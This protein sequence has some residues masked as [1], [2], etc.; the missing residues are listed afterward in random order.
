ML[1]DAICVLFFSM[2]AAHKETSVQGRSTIECT[3][4]ISFPLGGL[5]AL[6][7]AQIQ[8]LRFVYYPK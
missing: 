7:T 4:E 2:S 5:E 6:G 8:I 1:H 3:T